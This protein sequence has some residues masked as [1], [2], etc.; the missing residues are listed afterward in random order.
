MSESPLKI[1]EKLDPDLLKLV[2]NTIKFAL[3]DGALP[4]K[5]KLLIA[6][7]LDAVSRCR[8]RC[9]IASSSGNTGWSHEG[10]DHGS[11]ESCSICKRDRQRLHGSTRSQGTILA[12]D[13]L[14]QG[15]HHFLIGK[16]A[17]LGNTASVIISVAKMST[18]TNEGATKLSAKGGLVVLRP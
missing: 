5:F 11:A 4:R 10:R 2:E 16:N 9:K 6:M 17:H 14:S 3:A 8:S 15:V 13:R 7:A 12:V 18:E 1:L